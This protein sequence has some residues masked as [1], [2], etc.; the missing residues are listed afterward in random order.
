MSYLKAKMHQ[1]ICQLGLCPRSCWELTV[2]PRLPSWILGGI[3][4]REGMDGR[5]R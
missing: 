5:E 4:L 2:L 3:L 1:I